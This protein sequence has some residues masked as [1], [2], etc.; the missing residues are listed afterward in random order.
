[1]K[2]LSFLSQPFTLIDSP[3]QKLILIGIC[4]GFGIIFANVFVPFNIN[5]WEQDTGMDQFLRLTGYQ[6]VIALSLAFTQF[7]FRKL[8]KV[9]TFVLWG[10]ILWFLGE[11]VLISL[12]YLFIYSDNINSFWAL[13]K[14]SF[15]YTLLGISV[16][17]LL[18]L[19]ILALL[20]SKHENP[21]FSEK[22]LDLIGIPDDKGVIKISLRLS[23]LLY[24]ESADNYIAIFY[25]DNGHVKKVLVRNTLKT[26]EVNF[27]NSSLK[28]CHRSFIVN[29]DKLKLAERKS[30]KLYLHMAHTETIIPVSR[31]FIPAFNIIVSSV[32]K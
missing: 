21:E 2:L 11:V 27:K 1:M 26:I 18:S 17:Y 14:F 9:S 15:Q 5:Q 25:L 12:V 32:P 30:G 4:L 19:T 3:K 8:L 24:I 29:V 20:K 28:R 22:K 16:P 10:F 13:F 6:F 31:N 23:N 7:V